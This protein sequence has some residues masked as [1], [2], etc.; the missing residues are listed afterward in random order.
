MLAVLAAVSSVSCINCSSI[1][2]S[3]LFI[4][5]SR[6]RNSVRSFSSG[7]EFW[8]ERRGRDI[9]S[10]APWSTRVSSP[11]ITWR[12][13]SEWQLSGHSVGLETDRERQNR[14]CCLT[15]CFVSGR[16]REPT[17]LCLGRRRGSCW[18]SCSTCSRRRPGWKVELHH[19]S[20]V[21]DPQPL[22]QTVSHSNSDVFPLSS[23]EAAPAPAA[24]PK[25]KQDSTSAPT[26][27]KKKKKKRAAGVQGDVEMAD[28]E[29]RTQSR[30][31]ELD[32]ETVEWVLVLVR[33]GGTFVCLCRTQRLRRRKLCDRRTHRKTIDKEELSVYYWFVKTT[34]AHPKISDL[35][36]DVCW[37]KDEFWF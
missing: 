5:S 27:K 33:V 20:P 6:C 17:S 37:R 9:R 32:S 21:I 36:R 29:W 26:N 25:K 4:L 2:S 30:L 31:F 14:T 19:R 22:W 35:L 1:Y 3:C 24:P 34:S 8:A 28:I 11:S 7:G 12:R 18:N 23:A 13:E 15:L 10:W 16:A